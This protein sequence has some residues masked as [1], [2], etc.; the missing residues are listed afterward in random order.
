[1]RIAF[2]N[3]QGNF[4]PA[5]SYVGAHPDF[6]GQL[7]YVREV[8][9]ALAAMGHEVDILTRRIV[10]PAWPEFAAPA[11]RYPGHPGVRVL[12]FPCGPAGFLPKE[13]LWP[14]L[15]EWVEQ[16]AAW[17]WQAEAWPDLWTGHYG[18]GGVCAALLEEIS[19]IPFTFTAHSLG[20]W[21]LDRLFDP[22]G[23]SE[24]GGERFGA[25]LALIDARY[26]FGARLS[27]ETAALARAA[28][29]ITST[30]EERYRQYHHPAYA[31]WAAAV[32]G[33]GR[34]TVIPPGVNLTIFD[35]ASRSPRE[36]EIHRA[37]D[38]A[39]ERD[40]APERRHL[41]AVI[42]WNRLDPKKNY[43]SL[44]RAFA[45]RPE[46]RACANLILIT[47]G[48]EDP[49][50][51]LE[52]ATPMELAVLEP[53]VA[54]VERDH[55]WGSISAFHLAGQDALA[56]LYR[57]GAAT[58]SVFCLPSLYEPFGLSLIEAMAAG[59]PVVATRNGGPAEIT[60]EGRFGLL[61]DPTDPFDL[62]SQLLRVLT[63]PVD[64]ECFARRGREHAIQRYSWKECAR[65]YAELA[66]EIV[67][68][69]RRRDSSCPLPAFVRSAGAVELPRLES[70]TTAES[71][72]W[73]PSAI[74]VPARS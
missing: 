5:N 52:A 41:P 40:I 71:S 31:G 73:A 48:L 66:A 63:C 27:A 70:W 36:D 39:L 6:G 37:I 65:Q 2:V 25:D 18:D 56:A 4:D 3:P 69:G 34:F 43:Q 20:A 46:L 58:R 53:L 55:L 45:C 14:H 68:S 72:I 54:E 33:A 57:W 24:A 51:H 61:A 62:A 32:E 8:A 21:K 22:S 9:M 74:G 13:E 11:A 47:R 29:V 17:Y 7:V 49:L 35:A 50:R 59:L 60:E 38:A 16:I 12:R 67:E 15:G 44:V 30:A 28:A 23:F 42:A 19:G 10:D 64:W 1:V 26:R